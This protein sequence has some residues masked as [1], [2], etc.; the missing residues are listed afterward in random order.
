M[1][2]QCAQEIHTH[3]HTYVFG[4]FEQFSDARSFLNH[5]CQREVIYCWKNRNQ[6]LEIGR[7]CRKQREPSQMFMSHSSDCYANFELLNHSK[8]WSQKTEI[9]PNRALLLSHHKTNFPSLFMTL[10]QFLTKP[11]FPGPSQTTLP[12][13]CFPLQIYTARFAKKEFIE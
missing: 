1:L 7:Q 9:W 12:L 4:T 3:T 13:R 11:I 8:R 5:V 10:Q 2:G 6:L